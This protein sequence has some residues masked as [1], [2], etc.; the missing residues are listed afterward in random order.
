MNK[1]MR[2]T[3]PHITTVLKLFQNKDGRYQIRVECSI[4]F[5]FIKWQTITPELRKQFNIQYDK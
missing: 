5:R 1:Q 4:C 3:C 2:K